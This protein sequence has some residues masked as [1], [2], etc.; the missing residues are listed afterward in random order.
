MKKTSHRTKSDGSKKKARQAWRP[1]SAQWMKAALLAMVL[2]CAGLMSNSVAFAAEDDAVIQLGEEDVASADVDLRVQ[3]DSNDGSVAFGNHLYQCI[4][5]HMSWHDAEEYCE[6]QGGHLATVESQEENDFIFDL[7][8]QQSGR[9]FYW[10]GGT[11]E[12]EEGSWVWVTGE[13]WEYTNW[14][15]GEP[16]NTGDETGEDYLAMGSAHEGQWNDQWIKDPSYGELVGFVCEWDSSALTVTARVTDP[17]DNV[18][19]QGYTVSWYAQD[20]TLLGTGHRLYNAS[21]K[22]SY[23]CRI[24]LG[25]NLSYEYIQ[26]DGVGFTTGD[27]SQS[28]A[29][30]LS[31][32]AKVTVL[33]TVRR[34]DGSAMPNASIRLKQ[35]FNGRYTQELTAEADSDGLFCFSDVARTKTTLVA[36]SDGFYDGYYSVPMESSAE[37]IRVDAVLRQMPSNKITLSL[38]RQEAAPQGETGA[39]VQLTNANGLVFSAH[40]QTRDQE[41]TDLVVQY[42]YIILGEGTADAGDVIRLSVTDQSGGITAQDIEVTLDGTKCAEADWTLLQNGR[43]RVLNIGGNEQNTVMVFNKDGQRVTD[44]VVKSSYD[45]DPLAKGEYSLVFIK[46]TPALR[47]VESLS[48]LAE[49]GLVENAD[50]ALRVVTVEDGVISVVDGVEVPN[51]DEEKFSHTVKDKTMLLANKSEVVAGQYVVVRATYEMD[52]EYQSTGETVRLQIPAGM[53]F[54]PQSLTVDG[55]PSPCSVV[56]DDAGGCAVSV[57]VDQRSGTVRF[58]VIPTDPGTRTIYA[59]LSYDPGAVTQP[60]GS[61]SVEVSAASIKMPKRT[62]RTKVTA[63][64]KAIAG[65]EVAVYDNGTLVGSTTS[66]KIGSW[67]LEFDLVSPR[68]FSKH[69]V[70]A[71][72]TNDTYGISI[73]TD[74][75]E[76]FYNCNCV[77][78]SKVTMVNTAHPAT[79]LDPVE[80]M[81]V[82][83]F[84]NPSSAVPTYNYWPAYPTFTFVV[85]FTGAASDS[86]SNVAVVTTDSYGD[87]TRV[88]CAFDEE[89]GVWIGTFDYQDF[90]DVPRKVAVSCD[91]ASGAIFDYTVDGEEMEELAAIAKNLSADMADHLGDALKVENVEQDGNA[92]SFDLMLENERLFGY[93]VERLDYQSFDFEQWSDSHDV[94]EKADGK[95]TIYLSFVKEGDTSVF[96][97]VD[98]ASKTV[99]KETLSNDQN[100]SGAK[101]RGIR[102]YLIDYS[103]RLDD[104]RNRYTI[105][106]ENIIWYSVCCHCCQNTNAIMARA[107]ATAVLDQLMDEL[108]RIIL[109]L[110][111]IN[112]AEVPEP[113]AEDLQVWISTVESRFEACVQYYSPLIP[114]AIDR[115]KVN[116]KL[117]C[118]ICDKTCRSEGCGCLDDDGDDDDDDEGEDRPADPIADPSGYVYEAVP[119]NRVEGVEAQ[120]YQ[121]D[122]PVDEFGMPADQKSEVLWDAESYD[123][124]NPQHTGV[125]GTFGWDVPEGQWLVRFSKDGYQDADSHSDV[126]C[127]DEG[128]LP[129]PPIQTE[130]NTAIVSSSAPTVS[131]VR[132]Y[133]D[134]VRIDFSQYMQIDSVGAAGT[135]EVTSGGKAVVGTVEPLNAEDNYEG[136]ARYASSFSFRAE[137]Q[138]SGNVTVAVEG[139]RNYNGIAMEASYCGDHAVSEQPMG[140]ELPVG[141]GVRHH[142]STVV[143]VQ[144]LPARAGANQTLSVV[145]YSPSIVGLR[146]DE[147]VTDE[148]GR[149]QIELEGRLPGQGVLRMSLG[150][151]DIA[152]TLVVSVGT[153]EDVPQVI[154]VAD[155]QITIGGAS[156]VYNGK[157]HRPAVSV[158]HDGVGLALGTDYEVGFRNNV[159][160]GT[161]TVTVTG[162]GR[163][164]GSQ[165]VTFTIE[166]ATQTIVTA[167]ASYSVAMGKTVALG[168]ANKTPGGGAIG[169]KTS[170][171]KVAKVSASGVVTPVGVGTVTV[172]LTAAAKGNYKETTKKVTV[173]VTQGA[174]TIAAANMEC[175]LGK[176][177]KLGA[178]ASGGGK[179]TY[180]SSSSKVATVSAK[181]VVK[182]KKVGTVKVTVTAAATKNWKKA[183]KVVKVKVGKANPIVASA[184]KKTISVAYGKVKSKAVAT[185]A[186]V[187][188]SKAK[189]AVSFS[190][191][192]TGSIAKKFAVDAKTGKVTV[193]KKTKKGKYAVVVTATAAGNKSYVSGAKTVT[194]TIRV[195]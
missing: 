162:V 40:N 58:Y 51:L 42:P 27:K 93:R 145:S 115:Y 180:K 149:A 71:T 105:Q 167:K 99:L 127:D 23:T 170:D 83:D 37:E 120:I 150:G 16:S 70:Y 139:A 123:Q 30:S 79:S 158:T 78:V 110:M 43:I 165:S 189:G 90:C 92:T 138:M 82:F 182:G 112:W 98:T 52:S 159:N 2:V 176:T 12:D 192:S 116:G 41:I 55:K 141:V 68:K 84:L 76:L 15:S 178:K 8:Q 108:V 22:T 53:T 67:S 183:T 129:V 161:A 130:V 117:Y 131:S 61:A 143:D 11:D 29:I 47:S 96:Y 190:N 3:E 163:Y 181:G 125:D 13:P 132:A 134:H 59:Y 168:G 147:V 64:G 169:Y 119:S 122:Y 194:Y 101:S 140:L 187:R 91:N 148:N 171:A 75:A 186:N 102:D 66:N 103:K 174:Q 104:I 14:R 24:A 20:G 172:S 184:K 17:S 160:A 56:D 81:T 49:V 157:E 128:Y 39:S 31:P 188:V 177:V 137:S 185:A 153:G 173:V 95:D 38:Y 36:T 156:F 6:A 114:K 113:C 60:I 135:I 191:A 19:L 32:L 7:I 65:C 111:S 87:K 21:A 9:D 142:G 86:V 175:V 97:T 62:G 109:P 73:Q 89:G 33:G 106:I 121:Y 26:P 152:Q 100:P 44:K 88:P 69:E 94:I 45:S 126:A 57:S 85:E 107:D 154:D 34:L 155:C 54:V 48:K 35:T 1:L 166:A 164:A 72:V 151:T 80:F 18:I 25:E 77:E 63:S 74:V 136:T 118:D 133:G 146:S 28:V 46:K 179:L 10:L 195:K 124:A 5:E 50:Y 193:P 144:V 4:N